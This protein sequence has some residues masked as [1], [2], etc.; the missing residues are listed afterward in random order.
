MN[1]SMEQSGAFCKLQHLYRPN[2]D[3]SK[4]GTPLSYYQDSGDQQ[5]LILYDPGFESWQV[6]KCVAAERFKEPGFD[7]TFKL[8]MCDRTA[9]AGWSDSS[10]PAAQA[11]R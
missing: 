9:N 2:L 3:F 11:T 5:L 10:L 6:T 7:A 4:F 8:S 1:R